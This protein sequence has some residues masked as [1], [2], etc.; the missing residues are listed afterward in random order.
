MAYTPRPPLTENWH[1]GGFLVS[2]PRGRR[3]MDRGLIAQNPNVVLPGTVLG[4][5]TASGKW[6][7]VTAAANDGSQ[8]AAAIA[9]D[10]TDATLNDVNAA[11]VVRDC[12]VNAAEL[13][14]DATLTAPEQAAA[15]AALK[16][17]GIIAR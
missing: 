3:H 6:T 9:F 17:Q 11:L 15:L 14:W 7:P 13:V 5:I 16:A 10:I 2:V 4:Q 1:A 8:T 12:E